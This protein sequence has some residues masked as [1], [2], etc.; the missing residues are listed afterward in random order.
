MSATRIPKGRFVIA[1]R[2]R[3]GFTLVEILVVIAIIGILVALLLPAVQAA[4]EAGRRTHCLN[5]LKQLGLAMHNYHDVNRM[6]PYSNSNQGGY[7]NW[8]QS[9]DMNR[10]WTVA[11]LPF[12]EART[13]WDQ[14]DQRK[15]GLASPNLAIIQQN[16]PGVLCPSDPDSSTPLTRTD[17]ARNFVL[18]LSNYACSVGDHFNANDEGNGYPLR[19]CNDCRTV[20]TVRGVISRYGWSARFK[21]IKD[22]LSTT[23][24]AG[25]VIPEYCDWEDWGHQSFSTTARPINHRNSEFALSFAQNWQNPALP[26][27]WEHDQ[28][29]AFRSFHPGGAQFVMCDGTVH[30]LADDIDFKLYRALASRSG[31][32]VVENFP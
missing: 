23:M 28:S 8:G 9:G 24:F 10:S 21:H 18:A 29:I 1:R 6:L 16:L 30:F 15:D 22:G 12:M 25:E 20:A 31:Q 17:S 3:G 14:M 2:G 13:L 19:Y 27:S 5:N 7:D 26:H 32:E 11:L 4:R